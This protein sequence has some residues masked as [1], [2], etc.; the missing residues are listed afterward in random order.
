MKFKSN[1]I[2]LIFFLLS[3][4]PTYASAMEENLFS[5]SGGEE[6]NLFSSSGGEEEYGDKVIISSQQKDRFKQ[7]CTH[8]INNIVTALNAQNA[9]HAQSLTNQG[10]ALGCRINTSHVDKVVSQIQRREKNIREQQERKRQQQLAVQRQQQALQEQQQQALS[11]QRQAARTQQNMQALQGFVNI[12]GQ[13]AN[14][15]TSHTNQTWNNTTLFNN[16][17]PSRNNVPQNIIP[18]SQS[19][20]LSNVPE[21]DR[22]FYE[23]VDDDLSG[24]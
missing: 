5:S 20:N 22:K 11:R 6:E 16:P 10:I 13:M 21:R 4:V 1:I 19:N 2:F 14:K 7:Q 18:S 23:E 24:I 3:F 17:A 8:L 15:N 12:L 9:V